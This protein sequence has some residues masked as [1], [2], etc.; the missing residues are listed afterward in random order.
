MH[1]IHPSRQ[2]IGIFYFYVSFNHIMNIIITYVEILIY[3]FFIISI[4]FYFINYLHFI[5]YNILILSSLDSLFLNIIFLKSYFI[6]IRVLFLL[7]LNG[8][9]I[10]IYR[11]NIFLYF[12][13][14]IFIFGFLIH[15]FIYLH[16]RKNKHVFFILRIYF[17]SILRYNLLFYYQLIYLYKLLITIT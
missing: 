4:L 15:N 9:C 17:F 13:D 6:L 7:N 1:F 8:K 10:I 14:N 2:I 3:Y 11:Y 16:H 12:F 5:I